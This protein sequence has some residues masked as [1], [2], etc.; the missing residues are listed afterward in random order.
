MRWHI[1]A[2]LT[3]KDENSIPT[4]WTNSL[5]IKDDCIYS[6]KVVRFNYP[7]YN[8][9]R[10]QDSLNPRTHADIILLAEDDHTDDF[11]YWFARV[12]GV[13]HANIRFTSP[14]LTS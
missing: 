1:L 2:R 4:A 3:G 11:P 13:Y 9:R 10:A 14:G 7:T 12:V 5:D 6:H 8:M